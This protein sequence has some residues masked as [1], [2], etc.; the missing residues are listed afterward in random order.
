MN[1]KIDRM[2]NRNPPA[3]LHLRA[4]IY[5]VAA[6]VTTKGYEELSGKVNI[7]C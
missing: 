7:T 1:E 2:N 3:E 6:E 4:V 5:D